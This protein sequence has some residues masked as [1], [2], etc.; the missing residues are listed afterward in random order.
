MAAAALGAGLDAARVRRAIMNRLR[1]VGMCA[2]L[3]PLITYQ[4]GVVT[5]LMTQLGKPVTD[6]ARQLVTAIIK[7]EPI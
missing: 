7:N 3:P 1:T 2:D 5:G 6:T 4:N